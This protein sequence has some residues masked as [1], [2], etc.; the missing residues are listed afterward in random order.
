MPPCPRSLPGGVPSLPDPARADAETLIAAVAARDL[1][2]V[3]RL[4][5]CLH[6]PALTGLA[7]RHMDPDDFV[8]EVLAT[9]VRAWPRYRGTEFVPWLFTLAKYAVFTARKRR[10]RDRI[11]CIER[12]EEEAGSEPH[13]DPGDRIDARR[14]LAA[15]LDVVADLEPIDRLVLLG[16]ADGTTD[17]ELAMVARTDLGVEASTNAIA[18]RRHR[19]RGRVADALVAR[20]LR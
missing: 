19:A 8:Q 20:G 5:E 6:G 1:P 18:I 7:P 11:V 12:I 13:P 10:R 9:A 2:E 14:A 4:V 3:L 16:V 17:A 15:A